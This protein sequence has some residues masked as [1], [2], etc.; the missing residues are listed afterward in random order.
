MSRT[1]LTF[2]LIVDQPL[3][4]VLIARRNALNV[5]R[6]SFVLSACITVQIA[7]HTIVWSVVE[8]GT[9]AD[10]VKNYFVEQVGLDAAIEFVLLLTHSCAI[11]IPLPN[12]LAAIQAIGIQKI[13]W[14][15][16][17][18]ILSL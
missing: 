8:S 18:V 3:K 7:A 17:Q 2:A 10:S 1:C 5:L 14:I 15:Q 16:P 4:S 9:S 13:C 11:L 6:K 12:F